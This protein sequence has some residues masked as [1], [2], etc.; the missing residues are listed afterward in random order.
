[1]PARRYSDRDR[2]RDYRRGR[3][4]ARRRVDTEGRVGVDTHAQ[5]LERGNIG[6]A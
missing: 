3:A 5:F 4:D 2:K 1:L 6:I